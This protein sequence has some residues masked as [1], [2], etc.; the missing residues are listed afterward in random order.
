MS[1]N[2]GIDVSK[3]TFHLHVHETQENKVFNMS[4]TGIKKAVSWMLQQKPSLIILEATGGYEHPLLMALT[5]AELPVSIINPRM[6]RDFARSLGKLAKTDKLD[7]AIIARYAAVLQPRVKKAIS[8]QQRNLKSLVTRRRQLIDLRT[9]EKNH[10]EHAHLK[11]I[12][13]SIETVI[14]SLNNQIAQIEE[15]I[16]SIIRNNPEYEK[17]HV[18][19]TSVPGVGQNTASLLLAELPELGSFN[20]NQIAALV[21]LAP[22]NR[23]SGL[24][25]GRRMT[26]GGRKQIRTALFMNMLCIIQHNKKR[27]PFY[28]RLVLS[29]KKK[30]VALIAT[31]RKLI[32]ILNSMIKNNQSWNFQTA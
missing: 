27:S 9:V 10:L 24:F 12:R 21:G 29:G 3:N 31:M 16:F 19:L 20:R 11:T 15:E 22:I 25:R 30:M 26:G 2:I 23:D 17:K 6:I 13:S 32:V 14:Q 28:Q 18:L 8:E 7:A 4:T 5:S 1:T